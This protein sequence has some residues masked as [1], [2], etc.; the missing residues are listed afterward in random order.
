MK[1]QLIRSALPGELN[2]LRRSLRTWAEV[3]LDRIEANFDT[4]REKLPAGM[5]MLVILK[6]DAYGHGSMAIAK[7]LAHKADYFAV[8]FTD[9]AVA[10]RRAGIR[11]PLMMLGHVPR[12][13]YPI[14]VDHDIT[15]TVSAYGDAAAISEI[16]VEQGKTAKIHLAIDTGMSRI[17]FSVADLP[18]AVREIAAI[19]EL[20]NLEIE[21]VF[22]HFACADRTDKSFT[23]LQ[24]ARFDEALAALAEIGVNP[25]LRHLYNSAAIVTLPPEYDMVREGILLYGMHPS[26]EVDIRRIGDVRPALSLYTKIVHLKTLPAGVPV[27][28]GGSYVTKKET[29]VATLCAGYAD[30]VPRALSNACSL[31][32][33]G[34]PVPIIGRICMDQFM[35]DV[36]DVPD[37]AVGDTVTIIGDDGDRTIY[38]DDL[39]ESYGSIGY[40]LLCDINQRVPR[41]YLRHGKPD[42]LRRILPHE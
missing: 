28:Y 34:K 42:S 3:D 19:R 35:I 17:G 7:L 24:K 6:A 23:A 22:S 39:A 27:S 40:E 1:E 37:A 18:A 2:E 36:S 33:H 29:V 9:E 12:S 8:A 32:L 20:P 13:D 26:P 10:L 16:A 30:G 31:L 25:P 4:V 14:V 11:T 41:V 5:K 15:A 21:G 38:A